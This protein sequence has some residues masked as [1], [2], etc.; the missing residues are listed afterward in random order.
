[1]E[2]SFVP[3]K[4]SE[5]HA[6]QINFKAKL[7]NHAETLGLGQAE[8]EHA[9]SLIDKN[10]DSYNKMLSLRSEAGSARAVYSLSKT[11]VE[12]EL[13]RLSHSIKSSLSYDISIGEDLNII[14]PQHVE[15]PSSERKPELKLKIDG[16]KVIIRYNKSVYDLINLYSR[17]GNETEFIFLDM[18]RELFYEDDR[19]KLESGKPEQREYYAY[20][21]GLKSE[22]G[23]R[24]DVVKIV[25]P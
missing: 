3:R 4:N 6:F 13:R 15:I 8:V 7:S 11:A 24:S 1:M 18:Y 16:H 17:R 22:I 12:K 19:P 10:I 25:I 23:K 9:I 14:S 2:K 5:L 20:F 21:K